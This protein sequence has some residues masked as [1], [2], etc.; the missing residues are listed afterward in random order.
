MNLSGL[1]HWNTNKPFSSGL[2]HLGTQMSDSH[3]S[4]LNLSIPEIQL[5]LCAPLA[6]SRFLFVYRV[7]GLLL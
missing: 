2:A 3:N 6:I 4:G 1:K 5:P 7:S